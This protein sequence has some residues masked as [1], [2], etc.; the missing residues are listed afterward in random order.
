MLAPRLDERGP[1]RYEGPGRYNAMRRCGSQWIGIHRRLRVHAHRT[2]PGP[3][4][5]LSL[6]P[7]LEWRLQPRR[8]PARP[9]C[10]RRSPAPSGAGA[11]PFRAG[12]RANASAMRR[13]CRST[14]RRAVASIPGGIRIVHRNTAG[15]TFQSTPGLF[16]FTVT[17][18]NLPALLVLRRRSARSI[19][20]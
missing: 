4:A 19:R 14:S 3:P 16:D 5:T 1:G 20:S 11:P 7:N 15:R 13:L 12:P 17:D 8:L 18:R 9:A 2:R 6:Q 10:N